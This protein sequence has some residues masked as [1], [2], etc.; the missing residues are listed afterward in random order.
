VILGRDG[1]ERAIGEGEG[2]V[3][4]SGVTRWTQFLNFDAS[5]SCRCG[6]VEL[7]KPGPGS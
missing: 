4:L 1:L 2:G 3:T 5:I 6:S 7:M